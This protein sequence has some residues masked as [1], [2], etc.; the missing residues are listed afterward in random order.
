MFPTHPTL[1]RS[2]SSLAPTISLDVECG[3]SVDMLKMLIW[4]KA[5][6]PP[7]LLRL[8]FQ[9]R[10]LEDHQ[11]L[12]ESGVGFQSIIRMLLRLSGCKNLMGSLVGSAFHSLH[13]PQ[14]KGMW[15]C[16]PLMGMGLHCPPL[17]L[18]YQPGLTHWFLR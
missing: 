12:G 10:Q 8:M 18:W 4:D 2:F 3:Y 15:T 11:L 1:A 17:W 9:G 5:G 16:L 6:Y 13:P 7:Y 14:V